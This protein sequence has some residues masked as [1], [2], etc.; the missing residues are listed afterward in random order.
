MVYHVIALLIGCDL[1]TISEVLFKLLKNEE[2]I[3]LNQDPLGQQAYVVQHDGEGYILVK[4]IEN[5]REK[6]R[7]V[8]LYNPSDTLCNFPFRCSYWNWLER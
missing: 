1:T 4:D 6:V 3:A 5:C 2:L 7:A 8:A